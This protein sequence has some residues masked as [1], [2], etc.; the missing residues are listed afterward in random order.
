MAAE[1][2]NSS[3]IVGDTAVIKLIRRIQPGINPE[4]EMARHLTEAGYAGVA[5]FL[6]E[7]VW[8]GQV[9]EGSAE[10]ASLAV[11]QRFI[12]NQGDGWHWTGDQLARALDALHHHDHERLEDATATI[13][14]L[15]RTIGRRLKELH[16][17]L[18]R[19][20]EDVN[21]APEIADPAIIAAWNSRI[22][23]ALETAFDILADHAAAGEDTPLS[24]AARR[25]P[26][27]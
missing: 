21:F 13:R 11:I 19:P 20:S 8:E 23:Q 17:V 15:T 24:R 18:A 16:E 1:Q 12:R 27:A 3:V 2:T 10:T 22:G 5:E 26:R 6:G 14:A 9:G 25:V 4:V 7:L